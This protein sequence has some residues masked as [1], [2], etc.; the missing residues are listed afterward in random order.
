MPDL[1]A[2]FNLMPLQK[3]YDGKLRGLELMAGRAVSSKA[4]IREG[5][6]THAHD[7]EYG[8][9]VLKPGVLEKYKIEACR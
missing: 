6:I 2:D 5:F 1:V 3:Q 9:N 7:K 4:M 8:C